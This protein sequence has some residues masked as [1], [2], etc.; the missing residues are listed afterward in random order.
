MRLNSSLFAAGFA[1]ALLLSVAPVSAQPVI[2]GPWSGLY[3]GGN[4]GGAFDANKLSFSDQSGAQDLAFRGQNNDTKFIGGVHAGYDFQP[5]GIMFGVEGD[6]DFGDNI[7]YL[8]SIRG[9]VGVPLGPVLIYGTGGGAFEGAHEQFAVD[10]TSG[11]TSQ[12]SRRVNKNGWVAGAGVETYIMPA[13]SVGAEGL[14][15]DFGRDTADLTTP[16][17]TGAEPFS[18]ADD[19]KFAV[20]RARIT[21][22][23]GW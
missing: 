18:V 2:G 9:R 15:Y 14:W 21:Y 6:S 1:A 22:H 17:A 12:F 4:M 7:N 10:S 8:A 23:L 11:G 20:A 3:I 5:G 19:R 13:L 16:A